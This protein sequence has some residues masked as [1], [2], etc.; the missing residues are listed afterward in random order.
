M[1]MGFGN[2][3]DHD[4]RVILIDEEY[5]AYGGHHAS[6]DL[7]ICEELERRGIAY[8]LLADSQ[9][10]ASRIEYEV[11]PTFHTR[12][13][14]R[15]RSRYIPRI[16]NRIVAAVVGNMITTYD[17]VRAAT[18]HVHSGDLI[19]L[20]RPLS[21]TRISYAVWLR[22]L[23]VRARR[24]T[25]VYVVHN[26]PE[27]LFDLQMRV[28]RGLARPHRL[29]L[30]AH[31]PAV[32]N[33][34][35]QRLGIY[36]TVIPLPFTGVGF[37]GRP[38][39]D[40][41]PIRFAFLGLG[42]RTKGLDLLVRAVENSADRLATRKV[43]FAIQCYL[44]FMDTASEGLRQQTRELRTRFIGV[45]VLD[46]ELTPSD[47]LRELQLAH[48]VLIP[49][50]LEAY[51]FALSGVFADAMSAGRPVIVAEGSY[52]SEIVH[53]TGAGVT[54]ESGNADS[55]GEAID[56]ASERIGPLMDC[57]RAV[58]ERWALE[59]GPSAFVSRLLR[60]QGGG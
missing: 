53:Q 47:Y 33:L 22:F 7:P 30:V 44:P 41:E 31:S 14:L 29:Q 6:Y 38:V 51:R 45:E 9:L 12:A 4:A 2:H 11:I 35:R 34:V 56:H 17:L 57:A 48:V 49:H 24:V 54:F 42:H 50:R 46:Q 19:V 36:P 21:R 8:C 27:P 13:A 43:Q 55:L 59:H 37:V 58:A 52:M 10:D 25:I 40:G 32:A 20:C 3:V 26:K 16:V 60:L 39:V 15:L 28:L 1:T 23:A 18:A 5:G